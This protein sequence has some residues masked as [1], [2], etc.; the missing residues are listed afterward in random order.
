MRKLKYNTNEKPTRECDNEKANKP[1]PPANHDN[2]NNHIDSD[3]QNLGDPKNK[4]FF[5]CKEFS[6]IV[7]G[8]FATEILF[9]VLVKYPRKVRDAIKNKPINMLKT[10]V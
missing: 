3:K 5:E 7:G 2:W 9:K 8:H 10:M 6:F 1:L 4:M